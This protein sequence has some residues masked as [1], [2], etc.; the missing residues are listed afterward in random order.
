MYYNCACVL[1]TVL[2]LVLV[3]EVP[4][5]TASRV[6]GES[7]LSEEKRGSSSAGS[8]SNATCILEVLLLLCRA[9]FPTHTMQYA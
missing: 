8:A 2:V 5:G 3:L 6:S 4:P 1:A 9:T 7:W